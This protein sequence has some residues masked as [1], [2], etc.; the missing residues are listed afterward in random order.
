LLYPQGREYYEWLVRMNTTVDMPIEQIHRLG[1]D[2]V[3]RLT[4]EMMAIQKELGFTGTPQEF[5][6]TFRTNPKTSAKTAEEIG[7]RLDSYLRRIEPMMPKYFL[8]MPK[9]PYGVKRLQPELEGAQTFGYYQQ[10]TP[11]DPTGYYRF[12][13][14]NP[15]DKLLVWAG[16]LIYHEILPG[17]HYQGSLTLE[18]NL[19]AFRKQFGPNGYGEGWGEYSSRMAGEMGMYQ[20]PY[21]RY[22]YLMG[23]MML[24]VRL[25]VDTGMNALGWPRERAAAYMKEHTHLSDREIFTETLRYSVDIPGQALSYHL[26][27]LEFVRLREKA[28][29]ELGEKFDIREFHEAVLRPG[30]IP[31][32]VLEKHVEWW[33]AEREKR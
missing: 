6:A 29:K 7:E 5:R 28:K 9:A 19:P 20:D 24:A 8:R 14:A 27:M 1:M 22:G 16:S 12:N 10:P 18:S 17:H 32:T 26:G 33:I 3:K 11:D 31:L 13:G 23:E 15:Q 4:A 25:V 30:S 2:E 21:D